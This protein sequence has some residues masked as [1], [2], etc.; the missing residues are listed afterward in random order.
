[1]VRKIL[2]FHSWTF[3]PIYLMISFMRNPIF[4]FPLLHYQ[5][6][7]RTGLVLILLAAKWEIINFVNRF[8][9]HQ[10]E[11]STQ[12]AFPLIQGNPFL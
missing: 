8:R 3:Y 4:L 1:M 12:W 9:E 2:P 10:R 5:S 6:F 11:P 7:L